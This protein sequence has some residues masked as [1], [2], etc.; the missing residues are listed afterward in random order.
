MSLNGSNGLLEQAHENGAENDEGDEA[1]RENGDSDVRNQ[2]L[3]EKL[4][5]LARDL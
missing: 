5:I 1:V 4:G 3:N 2:G